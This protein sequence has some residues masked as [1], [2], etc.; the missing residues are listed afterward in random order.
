MRQ[1]DFEIGGYSESAE[2]GDCQKQ[3]PCV[4]ARC[5]VGAFEDFICEKC[6]FKQARMRSKKSK[7]E[8][9]DGILK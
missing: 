2:C 5:A 6:L 8:P 1:F 3:K 7:P 9:V 4:Y